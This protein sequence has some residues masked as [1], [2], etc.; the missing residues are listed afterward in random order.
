MKTTCAY[1][2][3]GCEM[4][5]GTLDGR[6]VSIRPT[7]E[8]PVNK[9]HLCVKG[10]YAYEYT[11]ATDRITRPMIRDGAR[12]RIASWDEA[13]AFTASELNRLLE[14]YGPQ[15]VGIL[16]SSRATNE[17]NYLTQKF[18][19][20]ALGTNNVD[21]CA[22]V[23][24]APSAAAMKLML[25]TGAATNSFDDIEKARTLMIC[26]ANPTGNHPIV[27]ARIK[28]AVL[29]GAHLI[30]IDPRQI[31]LAHY[32]DCHLQIRPGTNVALLNAMAATIVGEKLYDES[33]LRERVAEWEQFR[34]F[35]EQWSPE[36]VADTCGV[37][38]ALIRKAA[39]LYATEK[40]VISFHGLG[41]TEHTQGTEGVMCLVNLALLTGN[42]GRPGTGV[43]PLR[44]QNNVQGAAHMGCEPD[45]LTGYIP[46][47]DGKSRFDSLWGAPVPT[48]KGL[49]LLQMMDAAEEGRLKALW[50][51]GYDV[52]LTNA[53]AHATKRALQSLELVIIQDL[54]LNET[55]SA[56]GSVFLPAASSFEKDGT[57]MNAERRIQRVR[58]V[59]EPVG[60]S[61]PDWE[62]VC[63]LARALGKGE[64]FNFHSAEGIWTEARAVWP[65]GQ[66]ITYGR[67]EHGGLQWPCPTEAHPGT[68][69]LHGET[70]PI[71]KRAALRRVD[72]RPTAEAVSEDFP[73]LLVTGRNLY[74]FN[75]GT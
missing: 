50:S 26:G 42:L 62:I 59:V 19:R 58:K 16:G 54:F 39:R 46:I 66:G 49:N 68:E 34:D 5:V 69:V 35:I 56:F 57:F 51:I 2:G 38:A 71:G 21:C 24:H 4:N 33:F 17:E 15:S 18:A 65:A 11:Y 61:K 6:I 10:R 7:Q 13:I 8:A 29:R 64:F 23:C 75:A 37:E 48:T 70:F 73:F 20:V 14:Q 43:N 67:I 22:R 28:Q 55:A 3:T 1:C 9:G 72:Y 44:G 36:Q 12:W 41:L 27:G 63:A 45:H 40:P 52:V 30:V 74:Q 53:N 60:E 25:G 32:A 31:E 47:A